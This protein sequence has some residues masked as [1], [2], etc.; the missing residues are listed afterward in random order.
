MRIKWGI[1]LAGWSLAGCQAHEAGGESSTVPLAAITHSSPFADPRLRES[2]GVAVSYRHPGVLWTHND[3]GDDAWLYATDT[4]GRAL[5]RIR[6]AGAAN[7]DWEDLAVGPCGADRCVYLGDIG[8]NA[9]RRP[10]VQ[11]YRLPEPD[12]PAGGESVVEG[13]HTL[14]VTYP[15]GPDDV[16]AMLV[17]TSGAVHLITKGRS[18]LV[19]HLRIG[20]EAWELSQPV[21]AEDLGA[22]P[23]VPDARVGRLV[24]AAALARDGHRVVIRTYQEV[25]AGELDARGGL[26]LTGTPACDI[27]AAGP[28]GEAIDW[29]GDD[30]G[31]MVLTTERSLGRS[32]TVTLVRCTPVPPD[33]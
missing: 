6:L 24:T 26:A 19:R 20:P 11:L 8:D 27:R 28:A 10:E 21:Q 7:R 30:A 23:I 14:R 5:G 15:G 33:S 9:G 2:S 13:A 12:L 18:G 3:S 4:L 32:G 1:I 22:L 31:T 29:L 16:E 17:D 25:Y